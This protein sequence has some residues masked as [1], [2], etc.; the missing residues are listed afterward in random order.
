MPIFLI[1]VVLFLLFMAERWI[2]NKYWERGLSVKLDFTAEAMTEGED[3]YL[4][5]V[6]T[7]R[8]FI[9]LHIL[10]VNFQTD[11]GLDFTD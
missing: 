4:Q 6:I 11:T 3:T 10:Q 5:E 1:P 9:P 7:N 8:N 2:F